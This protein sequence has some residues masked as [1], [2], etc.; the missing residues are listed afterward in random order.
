MHIDTFLQSDSNVIVTENEQEE[1]AQNLYYFWFTK[2]K[3]GMTS[4]GK[5][6]V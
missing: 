3:E 2:G 4:Y 6:H 5:K 1:G